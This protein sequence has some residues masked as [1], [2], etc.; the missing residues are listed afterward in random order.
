MPS[1]LLFAV[2]ALAFAV[3][4]QK[5]MHFE[6]SY[7]SAD[8]AKL[9][10]GLTVVVTGANSGVG[11]AS[12]DHFVQAGTAKVVIMACRNVHKCDA[13]RD[14][15]VQKSPDSSTKIIPL[16]LDLANKTS[17]EDFASILPHRL[18]ELMGEEESDAIP[19][20]DIL[21]N[22]AGIFASSQRKEFIEGIESHIWVNHLAH[23]LLTHLLWPNLLEGNGRVVTIS[24]ITALLGFS[25]NDW[26]FEDHVD[27]FLE[28]WNPVPDVAR[29]YARSKRANLFFAHELHRRFSP[30]ISAVSSHPGYSRTEI[31]SNGAKGMP[32]WFAKAIQTNLYGSM[33]PADASLTQVWAAIDHQEIPSGWYV[34]P[35]WLTFGE[36]VAIGPIMSKSSAHY[37]PLSS[38]DS[39]TLW[40]LSLETLG[41]TEFGSV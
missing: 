18:R 29:L 39:E 20:I 34:G 36:P 22:N 17:I 40:D 11:F 38:D 32:G 4:M 33:S 3:M 12:A 23:V 28:K 24:S 41:I 16:Q 9:S 21:M 37:W 25:P 19:P 14:K 13:A 27:S 2:A 35:K 30:E 10:A 6:A 5:L 7:S 15:I 8:I 26:W 31:W 1:F